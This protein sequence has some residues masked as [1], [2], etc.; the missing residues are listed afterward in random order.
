M[1]T[2]I[3]ITAR[4]GGVGWGW[5]WAG[6]TIQRGGGVVGGG[7]EGVQHLLAPGGEAVLGLHALEELQQLVLVVGAFASHQVL[8]TG[9]RGEELNI[10]Y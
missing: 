7:V 5:G 1:V 8:V 10:R 4:G 2:N 3:T 9:G 6:P